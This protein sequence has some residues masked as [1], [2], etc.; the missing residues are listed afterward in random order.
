M[1]IYNLLLWFNPSP[2]T[3]KGNILQ[4]CQ[5]KRGGTE[6][7]VHRNGCA[8]AFHGKLKDREENKN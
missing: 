1:S 6:T 3:H 4:S 2:S 7:G 8:E 5:S